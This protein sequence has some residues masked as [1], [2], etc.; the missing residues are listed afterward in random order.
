[1]LRIKNLL[2]II[3]CVILAGCI[4]PYNPQI[5]G[6][7]ESKYVVS[8]RVTDIAGWQEVE[9]SLASPI[10][11]PHY[12]PV[13]GCTVTIY[14]D[15]GNS[16]VASETSPGQYFSWIDQQYLVHGTSFRLTVKTPDG[17][18]LVSGS[19]KMPAGP[20]LGSVYYRLEDVPTSNPDV[21]NRIM[22]FYT[23]LNAIGPYS[24]FYMWDVIETW[25]YHAAQPAEFYYDGQHHQIIPPDYSNYVCYITVPVKDV[26]TVTTKNLSENVY[27]QYPLHNIDGHSPRLGYL[28]S[29]LVKQLALTE[30]AYNYWDQLRINSDDQGGLYEKQP[31]AIKGN[32]INVTNPAKQVLGYFYTASESSQRYFYHDVPGL[33]LDFTPACYEDVLGRG[34]WRE[35]APS[36][37]PIYYYFPAGRL[38]ILS[39]ECVDCRITGGTLTKPDFWPR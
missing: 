21:T 6:D 27:N 33:V 12:I 9:V 13:Q 39:T 35:F 25:E 37:Y 4:K 14:D 34:G 31:L 38:K 30:E 11:S 20:P 22:Q 18:E 2:I 8:G 32:I 19:D 26:F 15:K 36:E 24:Q 5:D 28:Y 7:T 3:G 16:F 23:D 1:M 29:M 17:E 10:S